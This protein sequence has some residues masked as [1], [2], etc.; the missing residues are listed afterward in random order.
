VTNRV[1]NSKASRRRAGQAG[2][3]AR[4][5]ELT[6][7]RRLGLDGYGLNCAVTGAN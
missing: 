1:P 4:L 6:R 2:R 3:L 7:R 5:P